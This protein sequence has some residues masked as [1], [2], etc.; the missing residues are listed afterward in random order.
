MENESIQFEYGK[1]TRQ[2]MEM[3]LLAEW[4]IS[5]GKCQTCSRTENL[6]LDHIIP[7]IIIRDFGFD[8]QKFFDK[9]DLRL[10]CRPC[11]QLKAGRLDF[12]DPHTKELLLKYLNLLK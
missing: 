2:K 5:I 8:P 6:T 4:R 11:N 3:E 12:S 1:K 7:L 9:E 10:I